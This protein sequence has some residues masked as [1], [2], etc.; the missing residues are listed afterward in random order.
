MDRAHAAPAAASDGLDHGRTARADFGNEGSCLIQGDRAG[1]ARYEGHAERP[2][3]ISRSRFV[4]EFE[5][6]FRRRPDEDNIMVGAFLS[7]GSVLA[8]KAITGVNSVA[9]CFLRGPQDRGAIEIGGRAAAGQGI[10]FIRRADVKRAGIVRAEAMRMAIS[11]RLAMRMEEKL[12][13]TRPFGR[14]GGS[15]SLC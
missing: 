7:E 9:A 1:G 3:Q 14:T 12:I 4:A 11:P 6:G 15:R 2:G 5:Q 10:G 8:Q 13:Y